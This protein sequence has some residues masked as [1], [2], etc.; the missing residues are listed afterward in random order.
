[1]AIQI[2]FQARLTVVSS[3]SE[4][5]KGWAEK[6]AHSCVPRVS[7]VGVNWILWPRL[8]II[9]WVSLPIIY[10]SFLVLVSYSL[11]IIAFRYCF[12]YHSTDVAVSFIIPTFPDSNIHYSFYYL[13]SL[14]I[15]QLPPPNSCSTVRMI[16]QA[17]ATE[18]SLDA[19]LR[20]Y[21]N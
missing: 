1:M 14:F 16:T 17:G 5:Q 10:N 6:Y 12:I 7:R 20:N 3:C 11:L 19:F 13:V 8:F 4:G 15:I 9:L 2:T 18:K 21:K